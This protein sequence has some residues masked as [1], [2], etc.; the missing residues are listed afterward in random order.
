MTRADDTTAPDREALVR[1]LARD[2]LGSD[3]T[4]GRVDVLTS[5]PA[6]AVL[7]LRLA[8]APDVVAK[9]APV[10]ARPAVDLRRTAAVASMVRAAGAPVA[11]VVAAGDAGPWQYLL[12]LEV[13]G[14]AWRDVVRQ[15]DAAAAAAARREIAAAVRAVH[16][17]EVD[18]FGEFT[19]T[20][21][22]AAA[23]DLLGALRRR[24]DLRILD[25]ARRE[26]F[27]EVLD[28]RAGLFAVPGRPT[29]CHDDLHHG[30]V[31]FRP[32]S[33]GWTLSGIIDWDKAWAGPAD[34]DTARLQFWD[35]MTDP[36]PDRH[37]DA[38]LPPRASDRDLVHQLL[39]CLEHDWA[40]PRHRGDTTA[41]LD[42]LSVARHRHPRPKDA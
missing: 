36:V 16:S 13:P 12:Q 17:V 29:V 38:A 18:G 7:V 25:T 23:P 34:A 26:L 9:L 6:G 39:W 35:D 42:A 32:A 21:E 40:T 1:G 3:T 2:A 10:T 19:A 11:A 15:L 28:E 41:V 22:V 37:H 27:L 31:L 14:R 24:A 8:D 4:I 5:G 30:N 33:G 20:G